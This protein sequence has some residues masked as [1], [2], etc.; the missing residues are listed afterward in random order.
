MLT[1]ARAKLIRSLNLKKNRKQ[2]GLFIV[3]GGKSVVEV[4]RSDYVVHSIYVTDQFRHQY[5]QYINSTKMDP[6]TISE[7]ELEKLGTFKTNKNALALVK[8]KENTKLSASDGEFVIMLDNVRDPGNFGTILRICDWYGVKKVIS[9][10]SSAD[11]YNPKVIAASMGSF[12]RIK[13]YMT[14]LKEFMA[15]EKGS[16]YGASMSGESIHNL[17][18][19]PPA[20]IVLGNE[21]QG[22]HGTLVP[23]LKNQ[24]TIPRFG[25]A[26]SLNVAVAGAII[27]DNLKRKV[28]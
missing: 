8:T 6:I 16:F 12:A 1:K 20:Y 13:I 23:F 24:I 2:T 26:E 15:V 21:S 4:L 5:H 7:S 11:P 10:R 18:I 27:L 19:H 22:I 3:E 28:H 14:D 17:K 25:E 9:S